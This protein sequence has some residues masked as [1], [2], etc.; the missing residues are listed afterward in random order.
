MQHWLG[1]KVKAERSAPSRKAR[2]L[3]WYLKVTE[4][5]TYYDSLHAAAATTN[6]ANTESGKTEKLSI[7][8]SFRT[9]RNLFPTNLP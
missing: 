4:P 8:F 7:T 6:Q 9:P 5:V 1:R 2:L 3:P